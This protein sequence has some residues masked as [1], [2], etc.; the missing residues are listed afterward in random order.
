MNDLHVPKP[1][2]ISDGLRQEKYGYFVCADLNLKTS[3][4]EYTGH[5]TDGL[6]I[7]NGSIIH[8]I[9]RGQWLGKNVC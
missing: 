8:F 7:N 6:L 4:G 9:E 3:S 2:S 5:H 1:F